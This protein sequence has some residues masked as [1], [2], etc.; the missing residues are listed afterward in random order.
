MSTQGPPKEKLSWAQA[1]KN[2]SLSANSPTASAGAATAAAATSSTMG[3]LKIRAATSEDV[4]TILDFIKGLADYEK[5][6]HEVKA[7]E[8]SLT[9]TLFGPRPYA[10]VIIASYDGKDAGFALYF[11]NYSTFLAKPGLYLEDL[12]VKPEFRAHGIGTHLLSRL[13]KIA[14]ERD[15]GRMEWSAL[16]WNTPAIDFYKHLGAVV[17]DEWSTFRLTGDNIT[18][19]AAKRQ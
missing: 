9:R 19:L 18:K 1:I 12:Y 14:I 15:C 6:L 10:E 16:N 2:N 3:D 8:E 11:F 7:T 4:P 5:L 17:M 13:A